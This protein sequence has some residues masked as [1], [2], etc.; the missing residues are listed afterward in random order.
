VQIIEVS[1]TGWRA[2]PLRQR[3][4]A[5][6]AAPLLGLSR[7]AFGS[8]RALARHL[9]LTDLDWHDKMLDIESMDELLALVGEQRDKL[10][11]AELDKIHR[12]RNHEAITV[13][14]VYGARHVVPV[15]QGMR[16]LHG[17]RVRGA[18]WLTAFGFQLD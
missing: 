9:E 5:V 18:E 14:I 13:G 7:L 17:Y 4:R 2:V 1:A 11:I 6:L 10:L 12:L 3:A 16:A 15:L 8:R